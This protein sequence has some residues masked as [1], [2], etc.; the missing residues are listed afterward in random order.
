MK[1]PAAA[2]KAAVVA[3]AGTI[4]VGGTVI[5]ETL[6]TSETGAPDAGAAL[7]R[8]TEQLVLPLGPKVAAVHCSD[9][10]FALAVSDRVA[11]LGTPLSDAVIMAV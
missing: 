1:L 7:E 3:P 8:P 10:M 6:L 4:T 9:V 2:V 5:E 11:V